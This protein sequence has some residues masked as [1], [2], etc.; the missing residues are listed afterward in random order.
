MNR[1]FVSA[2]VALMAALPQEVV[3]KVASLEG[4]KGM[5]ALAWKAGLSMRTGVQLQLRL[6]RIAPSKILQPKGGS[7]F[8]MTPEEMDWQLDFFAG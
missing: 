1:G 6:A 7:D 2:A 5:T 4:A 8:P 3:Q